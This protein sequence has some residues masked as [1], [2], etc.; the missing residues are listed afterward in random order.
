[1]N[2]KGGYILQPR[3]ID[4]S[5]VAK[6]PPHVRE[7]WLYLLR[8]ANHSDTVI[9]GTPINRGQLFTSYK[10]ILEDLSWYVGYRKEGYKKHHC[11]TAM[12]LLTKEGMIVTAK[13]TR[14]MI[15]TI[16]KYDYYQNPKNYETGREIDTERTGN[17]Q[18]TDT[19]NKNDKNVNND[20]NSLQSNDCPSEE[21]EFVKEK[22]KKKKTEPLDKDTQL[23]SEARKI[24]EARYLRETR[25]K[26]YWTGKDG[27]NMTNILNALKHQ[28][29]DKGLSNEN[30]TDILAALSMFINIAVKDEWIKKKLSV[31][32][33]F[34]QFNEIVARAK[35]EEQQRK[36]ARNYGV[37]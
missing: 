9:S 30:N 34:S 18:S 29:T 15:V 3:S 7:I 13:T 22:P 8:K 17:R 24:F 31:S 4:E 6:L 36:S 26:Y 14:G 35:A 16:C 10:D 27:G 20:N 25:E 12:R 32:I 19:I 28:R 5:G 21:K 37:K 2:I 1:M 33:L 11:E 23:N